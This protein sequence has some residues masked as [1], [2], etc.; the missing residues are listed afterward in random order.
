MRRVLTIAAIAALCGAC[1][2]SAGNNSKVDMAGMGGMGG[3]GGMGDMGD[4]NDAE[5]GGR[6]CARDVQCEDDEYCLRDDSGGRCTE[7]CRQGDADNCPDGSSC[8]ADHECVTDPCMNDDAC[9]ADQY[10]DVSSGECLDGCRDVGMLCPELDPD[11]RSQVCTESVEGG[12][13]CVPLYV[14]C[15]GVGED[16]CQARTQDECGNAGGDVQ[17]NALTCDGNP[18][19]ELCQSDA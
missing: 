5:V 10:C 18:C 9:P 6:P 19:G 11:G 14:C 2:D 12:R 4:M 15:T 13:Q 7:G 1:D 8:S 17:A 3:E 16:A